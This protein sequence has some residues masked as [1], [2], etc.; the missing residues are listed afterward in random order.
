MQ[1]SIVGLAIDTLEHARAPR[2]TV[3]APF[4]WPDQG[5]RDRFM[6]VGDDNRATLAA[7]GDERRRLQSDRDCSSITGQLASSRCCW[8]SR[9][10]TV[11]VD[12][13]PLV[14]MS[15]AP[16]PPPTVLCRVFHAPRGKHCTERWGEGVGRCEVGSSCGRSWSCW[17][18][19][20]RRRRPSPPCPARRGG[21]A[22]SS[23]GHR[24]TASCRQCS[25]WNGRQHALRGRAVHHRHQRQ[26]QHAP[27]HDRG[28]RSHP[29]APR[30]RPS[31]RQLN[32]AVYA[33]EASH[34][35][36]R[37]FVV[38]TSPP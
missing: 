27:G 30:S 6:H 28:L 14:A 26:H 29:P 17:R 20:A 18:S 7:L 1:R 32:G 34:N 25:P 22:D 33:L 2:T 11:P 3:Q 8:R 38:A 24:P 19:S 13:V 12:R 16:P 15:L 36:N 5:W 31:H 23:P 35:G 37:L 4:Q 21:S 9:S 10:V